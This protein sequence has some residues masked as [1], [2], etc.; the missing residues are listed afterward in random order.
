MVYPTLFG[1]NQD[2]KAFL[3]Q[4][5]DAQQVILQLWN[6]ENFGDHMADTIDAQPH[7]PFSKHT[8]LGIVSQLH[9]LPISIIL[10]TK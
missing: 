9:H 3:L 1:L 8:Q 2:C 10:I 6:I 7:T 4:L 5:S